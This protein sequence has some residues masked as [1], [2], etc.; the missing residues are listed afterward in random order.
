M[1]VYCFQEA[2]C[3]LRWSFVHL[4]VDEESELAFLVS[5]LHLLQFKVGGMR[6]V[7]GTQEHGAAEGPS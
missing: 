5:P 6:R 2:K 1:G 3:I 4:V 7:F